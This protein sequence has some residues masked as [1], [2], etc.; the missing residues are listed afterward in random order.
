MP[1]LIKITQCITNK[2]YNDKKYT[3]LVLTFGGQIGKLS[4]A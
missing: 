1:Y 4:D 3:L 2:L